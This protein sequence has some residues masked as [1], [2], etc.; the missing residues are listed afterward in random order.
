MQGLG[1]GLQ[2]V[3]VSVFGRWDVG[4]GIV[5]VLQL[6]VGLEG[7][8]AHRLV[9]RSRH[10]RWQGEG[11]PAVALPRGSSPAAFERQANRVR[12]RHI[13]RSSASR[14]AAC[15]LTRQRIV[16]CQQAGPGSAVMLPRFEPRSAARIEQGPAGRNAA[17]ARAIGRAVADGP[18]RFQFDQCLDDAPGS[19]I[20]ASPLP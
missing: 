17:C 10:M 1:A 7:M 9:S 5:L 18:G 12:M 13:P 20:C 16:C 3:R 4:R 14:M 6:V 2:R 11:R 15:E 8:R 19:S